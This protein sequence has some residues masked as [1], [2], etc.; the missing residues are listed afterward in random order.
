MY[1]FSIGWHRLRTSDFSK[2]GS[3]QPISLSYYINILVKCPGRAAIFWFGAVTHFRSVFL[4]IY[5]DVCVCGQH[6]GWVT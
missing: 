3:R 5:G 4:Y 1:S 6:L 2:K